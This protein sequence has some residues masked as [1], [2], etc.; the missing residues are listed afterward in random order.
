MQKVYSILYKLQNKGLFLN[1]GK[2]EFI[3]KSIKYLRFIIYANRKDIGSNPE[4]IKAV[5]NWQLPKTQKEVRRFF[6]FV[7]FY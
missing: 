7:N 3:Q 2:S 5:E 6:G 4:K 1:I